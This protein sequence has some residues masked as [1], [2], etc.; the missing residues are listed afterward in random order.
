MRITEKPYNQKSVGTEKFRTKYRMTYLYR[1]QYSKI[2]PQ[3][4]K[5]GILG[6]FMECKIV[7]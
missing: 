2:D 4:L 5:I 7:F 6:R 1:L 3:P